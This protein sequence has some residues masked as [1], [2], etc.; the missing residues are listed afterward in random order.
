MVAVADQ[1]NQPV[2]K[3]YPTPWEWPWPI[4]TLVHEA[5][6]IL[7]YFEIPEDKRPP[8]S[9]WHSPDKCSD[10]IKKAFDPDA[11]DKPGSMLMF[12]DAERQ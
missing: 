8:R 5:R 3:D 12:D 6:R 1:S 11:K 2:F 9:I 4:H 7:S 10:W